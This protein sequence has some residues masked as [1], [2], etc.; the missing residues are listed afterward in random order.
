MKKFL[1]ISVL[2]T[3]G[4]VSAAT[5]NCDF[6]TRLN[7]TQVGLI[8]NHTELNGY[9]SLT[10]TNNTD[11]TIYKTSISAQITNWG[12]G[13]GYAKYENST[14]KAFNIP[15]LDIDDLFN[16]FDLF[17]LGEATL[18]KYT[19]RTNI[20]AKKD[21][22]EFNLMLSTKDSRGLAISGLHFGTL[23]IDEMMID[24]EGTSSL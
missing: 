2:A 22:F 7:G 4:T 18:L 11:G 8:I 16:K 5:W 1:I 20:T 23:T 9:G 21:G 17:V 19:E 3:I 12:G 14:L 6:E 15:V 10:C 24:D 13:I